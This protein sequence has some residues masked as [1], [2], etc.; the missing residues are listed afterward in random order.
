[1]NKI[2]LF[3]VFNILVHDYQVIDSFSPVCSYAIRKIPMDGCCITFRLR[4]HVIQHPSIGIFPY[5]VNKQGI[6][7]SIALYFISLYCIVLYCIVLFCI[8]LFCIAF[9]HLVDMNTFI[10]LVESRVILNRVTVFKLKNILTCAFK[11][12]WCKAQC[13]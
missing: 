6:T 3:F 1:M 7:N 10:L 11:A 2:G 4:L 13:E 12:K 8:V 5:Y 9:H